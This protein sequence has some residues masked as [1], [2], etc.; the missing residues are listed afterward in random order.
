MSDPAP[1][2]EQTTEALIEEAEEGLRNFAYGPGGWMVRKLLTALQAAT[3]PSAVPAGWVVVPAAFV[4]GVT[5]LRDI[6]ARHYTPDDRPDCVRLDSG[7]IIGGK[8]GEV[9]GG[10]FSDMLGGLD[11]LL[12]ILAAAP[13]PPSP[14]SREEVARVIRDRVRCDA[15]GLSPAVASV[16]LTG[17]DDAADSILA[18]F[19]RG[20]Q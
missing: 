16:F 19:A 10:I 6:L 1:P 9:L 14:P 15:T 20:A 12:A 2:T 11:D 18:L 3:A 17:F 7:R 13:P 4:N 8:D 5:G